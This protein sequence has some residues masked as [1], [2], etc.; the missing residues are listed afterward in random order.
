MSRRHPT[1]PRQGR[2]TWNGT[3][4]NRAETSVANNWFERF[5][6]NKITL[7]GGLSLTIKHMLQPNKKGGTYKHDRKK[8]YSPSTNL[9]WIEIVLG[10]PVVEFDSTEIRGNIDWRKYGRDETSTCLSDLAGF[11]KC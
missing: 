3:I 8:Y 11:G 6:L 4:I 1:A 5:P 10:R 2:M 7:L 9:K